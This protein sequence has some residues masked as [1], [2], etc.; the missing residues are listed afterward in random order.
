MAGWRIGFVVGNAEVLRVLAKLKSYVDFGI[1]GGVQHAAAAALTRSQDCVLRTVAT[2][3]K[4][5]N[6]FVPGLNKAG[7]KI[8]MPRSTFYVWARIPEKFRHMKS[9]EFSAYLLEKTGV[10]SA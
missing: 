1:F 3:E 5:R 7:W 4:R 10:V 6:V 8:D 2:Y 9:L